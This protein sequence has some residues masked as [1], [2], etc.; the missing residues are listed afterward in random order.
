MVWS[1]IFFLRGLFF[2][3]KVRGKCFAEMDEEAAHALLYIVL[4]TTV[5]RFV[6]VFFIISFVQK[7]TVSNHI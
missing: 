5:L 4:E 2:M 6:F 1:F 7:T 3:A